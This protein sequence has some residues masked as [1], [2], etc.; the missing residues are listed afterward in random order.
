MGSSC[1]G[2][3]KLEKSALGIDAGDDGFDGDFFAIGENDAGDGAVFDAN[4][5]NFGV[6]ADFGAGLRWRLQRER[7]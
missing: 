3:S 2:S 1:A 6:G 4:V 7:E 5:L